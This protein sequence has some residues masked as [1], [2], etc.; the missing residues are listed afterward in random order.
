[1]HYRLVNWSI[2]LLSNAFCI[3]MVFLCP[4]LNTHNGS[5]EWMAVFSDLRRWHQKVNP[6]GRDKSQPH[7][8]FNHQTLSWDSTGL[9]INW[10]FFCLLLKKPYL[11]PLSGTILVSFVPPSN[12][13]IPISDPWRAFWADMAPFKGPQPSLLLCFQNLR[14]TRT[15][16][17]VSC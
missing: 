13:L 8:Y 11:S 10:I 16:S 6:K 17:G 3:C 2:R 15:P 14:D 9:T 7:T 12:S 1:M 4:E 5:P